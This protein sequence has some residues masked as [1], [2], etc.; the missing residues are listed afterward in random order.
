MGT[1]INDLFPSRF[2]KAADLKGQRRIVTIKKVTREE[3]GK[4]K[5]KKAVVYFG[6]AKKGLVLNVTNARKIAAVTGSEVIDQWL[7]KK[8]ALVSAEIEFG[9]DLVNAI[10]V[11]SPDGAD[12]TEDNE[13]AFLTEGG[14]ESA[15]DA[16]GREPGSD[17]SI[18]DSDNPFA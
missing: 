12:S 8:I 11:A 14:E 6:E 16:D 7:G 13:D 3:L 5:E 17:G 2:L 1:T 15:F 4:G 10:R 9:G 18:D